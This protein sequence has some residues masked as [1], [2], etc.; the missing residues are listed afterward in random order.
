MSD[1]DRAVLE[2]LRSFE[3]E[4]HEEA[5]RFRGTMNFGP[6]LEGPPG[7]VHGGIHPL[8]R[9][10]PILARLRPDDL[11]RSRVT[12]DASLQKA[13]PL[14]TDVDFDGTYRALD[15]GF[16]LRTRFLGSER[17][18]AVA[19]EPRVGELPGG[20]ALARF[21][22][23][24]ARGEE[25]PGHEIKVL[26]TPYRVCDST[27][28]LDLRSR[29]SIAQG[30]HLARCLHDDGS[31]GFTALCTQLDAVGATGRGARMRHP[32][33][34]KH[35]TLAFDLEGLTAD[36]PLLLIAD[37]TT[38]VEDD[39]PDAPKVE[40]KGNL[41]GSATV[42]VVAVRAD[43]QRCFAHGFVT[44]HP[45]DPSRYEGFEGMRKLREA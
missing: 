27:I 31:L 5:L 9:T 26:G 36:T 24:F 4:P 3:T 1:I 14:A 10:L 40:V 35:I 43:F 6:E 13:L 25:E 17:L 44:A 22:A 37:R 33:F 8:V 32:H 2:S 19:H 7:R 34:T 29:A 11:A 41:Y 21:A 20:E 38:I 45:V 12:I 23:L 15:E 18:S 42:E 39:A 28:V 30:S 16:E